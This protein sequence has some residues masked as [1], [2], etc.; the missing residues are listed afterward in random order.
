MALIC[1]RGI[2][3]VWEQVLDL[4]G[5]ST[6]RVVPPASGPARGSRNKSKKRVLV[7]IAQADANSKQAGKRD[8]G[9]REGS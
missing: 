9:Y 4:H 5:F 2:R 3:Q 1:A 6:G 7:A 8:D